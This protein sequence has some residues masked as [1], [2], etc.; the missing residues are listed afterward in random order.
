M[1]I[2]LIGFILSSFLLSIDLKWEQNIKE[3]F[4]KAKDTNKTVMIFVT[5]ESCRWCLKM[6]KRTLSDKKIRKRLE[7][8][9]LVKVDKNS[10]DDSLA[11]VKYFPTILFYSPKKRL[12][13]KIVGYYSISDFLS[14]IDDV[15]KIAG[16]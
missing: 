7:N 15:E 8:Y 13:Q 10:L 14:W 9:I 16:K 12:Y 11:K 1:R 4:L 6:K 5:K 2:F 3:A